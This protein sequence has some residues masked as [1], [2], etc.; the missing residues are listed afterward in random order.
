MFNSIKAIR[1]TSIITI[2][3]LLII[4]FQSWADGLGALEFGSKPAHHISK[5][6]SYNRGFVSK[7]FLRAVGGVAFSQIA[8]SKDGYEITDIKYSA[9][10]P[11]GSRL[12]LKLKPSK[13]KTVKVSPAIFDWQL[14]PISNFANSDSDS[15]FTL[16]GKLIDE[17]SEKE[18]IEQGGRILNYHKAFENTLM[19]LRLF[20]AD[21][22]II[23][24]NAAYLPTNSEGEYWKGKGEPSIDVEKNLAAYN[25]IKGSLTEDFVSYVIS[26]I[27]QDVKFSVKKGKLVFEGEPIWYFWTYNSE[28]RQAEENIKFELFTKMLMGE[29]TEAEVAQK[30]QEL[31]KS[32]DAKF[33]NP[34]ENMIDFS[35]KVSKKIA[36]T[37]NGVNP[38]VYN[39]VEMTM[40]Y[41]A[42]FR[43]I[44]KESPEKFEKFLDQLKNI[45]VK[46][47][48]TTPTYMKIKLDDL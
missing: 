13:G 1:L 30:A 43:H 46:P 40:H 2:F 8:K 3:F 37:N 11:D 22:L 9:K 4:P 36:Q 35:N 25:E 10:K 42:L 31:G 41:S 28:Y 6:L 27:N 34:I 24:K 16:F 20:Q 48:V 15:C 39:A 32:L 18:I 26:D 38:P 44:K 23:N 5:Q 17:E 29:I 7:G 45:K 47:D 12:Q 19:G 14:V 21:L 33:E